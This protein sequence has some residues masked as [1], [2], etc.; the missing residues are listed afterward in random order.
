MTEMVPN[1]LYA[2]LTDAL[3]T[4]EPLIEEIDTAIDGPFR[5]FHSGKVWS[6][7]AA[8][9]FDGEFGQYRGRSRSAGEAVVADIRAFLAR[10]PE[11]VTVEEAKAISSRYGLS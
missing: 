8:K 2:A 5:E 10:T 3:K 11:Q 6:G 9:R 1:P 7:P 4:V